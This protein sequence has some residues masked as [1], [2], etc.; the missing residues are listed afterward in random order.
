[1]ARRG[2]APSYDQDFVAWLED[3]ARRARRGEAGEL[4]LENIAEELEGMARGDR[5]EIR[6]RLIVLLLHLLKYSAQPRRRSS[7]WLSTIGEQRSRIATVID[8]SPSLR[9]FPGSI[10]DQCYVDARSRAALETGLSESSF[11]E[12]CPFGVVKC[13]TSAGFPVEPARAANDVIAGQFR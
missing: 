12:R 13:S 2:N 1:M 5:R 6:N 3:Q 11:P 4:D 8:D 10:L 9:P 7:G